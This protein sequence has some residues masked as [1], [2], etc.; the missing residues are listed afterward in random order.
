[1]RWLTDE[2]EKPSARPLAMRSV[3]SS[4]ATVGLVVRL[5]VGAGV[6]RIACVVGFSTCGV[7]SGT[8]VR[9]K[10]GAQP[11]SLFPSQYDGWSS[12]RRIR[13][14]RHRILVTPYDLGRQKDGWPGKRVTDAVDRLPSCRGP[15]R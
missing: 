4:D 2:K 13:H 3:G 14:E 6:R 11:V 1:M 15:T 9:T 10:A 5:A 7:W 8:D 12:E